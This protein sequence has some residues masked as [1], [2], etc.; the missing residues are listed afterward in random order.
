[1]RSIGGPALEYYKLFNS[2][3]YFQKRGRFPESIAMWRKVLELKP[4]DALAHGNLG[5][6][7]LMAGHR[8]EA[9]VHLQKAAELKLTAAVA[10]HPGDASAYRHLGRMLLDQG[11]PREAEA[12]ANL[13]KAAELAP[14]SATAHGDLGIALMRQGRLDESLAELRKS[15][16]LDSRYAPGYYNLGLVL[17]RKGE[18]GEA[19]RQWQKALEINPQYE[20]AHDS[21]GN[22]LYA[23]GS[24]AEALAHW[25]QGTNDLAALRQASWTLA[26]YPDPAIRDGHE[27]VALAVRALE[28]SRGKDAAV[29][30]ILAAA[31]AEA[32]QFADAVQTS[33]R[34]LALAQQDNRPE[35]AEAIRSR[36]RLYET[37]TPFRDAPAVRH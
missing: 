31:Y 19:I 29:W 11:R 26:T 10:D 22:A 20:E 8:D 25:R 34:A 27:A 32:G 24:V 17:E 30:D 37:E 7:L 21:L 15:L 33:A 23:R 35:L 6:A 2:A 4:D 3:M 13:R 14:A 5:T 28:L 18:T 9:G 1:L 12:V 16:D 36:M